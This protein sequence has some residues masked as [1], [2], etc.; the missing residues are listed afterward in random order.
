MDILGSILSSMEKP[1]DIDEKRREQMK[2]KKTFNFEKSPLFISTHIRPGQKEQLEKQKAYEKHEMHRFR[3]YCEDRINRLAK[4]EKRGSMQ[5]QT[6][7]R[8]YRS[9]V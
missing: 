1:P 7:N 5:F 6:L 2:S 4:D 8:F 9:I 3:K